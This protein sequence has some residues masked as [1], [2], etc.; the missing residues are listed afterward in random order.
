M[1]YTYGFSVLDNT[2]GMSGDL[3]AGLIHVLE[4]L[5][6]HFQVGLDDGC[7]EVVGHVGDVRPCGG[8]QSENNKEFLQKIITLIKL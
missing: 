1:T 5:G 8:D 7:R 2:L 3:V 4:A 6:G